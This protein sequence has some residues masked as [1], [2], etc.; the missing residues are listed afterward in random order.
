M[1]YSLDHKLVYERHTNC[2]V[3]ACYADASDGGNLDNRKC[4]SGFLIQMFGNTV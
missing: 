1:K 3:L 2:D 4:T